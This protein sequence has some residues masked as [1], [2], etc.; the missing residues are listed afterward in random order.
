MQLIVILA[1]DVIPAPTARKRAGN[2]NGRD[3]VLSDVAVI[4]VQILE[5]CLVDDFRADHLVVGDLYLIFGSQDVGTLLGKCEPANSAIRLTV[6]FILIA[7][8]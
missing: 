1:V 3:Q 5:P 2:G 7:H 4:L 6:P 8:R